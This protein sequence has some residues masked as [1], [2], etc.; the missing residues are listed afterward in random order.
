MSRTTPR[1]LGIVVTLAV[2]VTSSTVAS[3]H[4]EP[5]ATPAQPDPASDWTLL[6]RK[7]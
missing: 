4:A 7:G 3:A 2:F 1:V 5:T 6:I